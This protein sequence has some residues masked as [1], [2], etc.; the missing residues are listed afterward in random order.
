MSRAFTLR[1]RPVSSGASAMTSVICSELENE[2]DR[3]DHQAHPASTR[4]SA[5]SAANTMLKYCRMVRNCSAVE[6]RRRAAS[7]LRAIGR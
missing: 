6:A 1:T 4:S 2:I 5:T 3:R 7:T